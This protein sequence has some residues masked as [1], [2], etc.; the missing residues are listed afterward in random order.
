MSNYIWDLPDANAAR[1]QTE[2]VKNRGYWEEIKKNIERTI[3][4]GYNYCNI[5]LPYPIPIDI[6]TKLTS[7]LGYRVMQKEPKNGMVELT[8]EW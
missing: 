7:K 1:F 3:G 8:I 4:F 5:N 2:F 6:I